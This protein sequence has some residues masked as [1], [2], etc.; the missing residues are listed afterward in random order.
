[1]QQFRPNQDHYLVLLGLGLLVLLATSVAG[2]LATM[3]SPVRYLTAALLAVA[4]LP[5]LTFVWWARARSLAVYTIDSDGIGAPGRMRRPRRI[6]WTHV[7]AVVTVSL[8]RILSTRIIP[9]GSSGWDRRTIG[10][11][12]PFGGTPD[13][14]ALLSAL[15]QTPAAQAFDGA[16]R[17]LLEAYRNAVAQHIPEHSHYLGQ[18]YE[19]LR[20]G[21]L[22]DA[23]TYFQRHMRKTGAVPRDL[24]RLEYVFRSPLIATLHSKDPSNSVIAYYYAC[25]LPEARAPISGKIRPARTARRRQLLEQALAVWKTVAKDPEHRSEAE[26]RMHDIECALRLGEVRDEE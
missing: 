12:Y 23:R 16:S 5:T 25:L 20:R 9:E 18:A 15:A 1:M 24:V 3:P 17:A 8:S 26:R 10:F 22:Y 4:F 6:K 13:S 7:Q 11:G 21:R 2:V 14:F 19:L